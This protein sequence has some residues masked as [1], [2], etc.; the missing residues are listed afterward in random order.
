MSH[1]YGSAVSPV[2]KSMQMQRIA[3][4]SHAGR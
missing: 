2:F 1:D 3:P 4:Q